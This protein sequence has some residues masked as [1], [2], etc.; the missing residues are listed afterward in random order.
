MTVDN[1][2][3]ENVYNE[4]EVIRDA[5]ALSGTLYFSQALYIVRGFIIAQVLGPSTYGVWSIFRSFFGSAPYFGMGTQQAMLREVPFS[6]GEGDKFKKKII[7]Q[8]TL[9]WNILLTSV[10]MVIVLILSFTGFAAGYRIEIQLAG[11]LFVLNAIH[12]F[13]RPKFKSEQKIFLLSKYLL[14]YAVLNTV[15]GLSFLF[16][17]KLTGLLMGMILAQLVLLTFLIINN[18]L[19]LN[20][21]IDKNILKEL[22][23]IGFPIMLLWF[24]VFLMGNADKFIVFIMLGKTKAGYYGLAAFVSSMVS[25]ISYSISTVIFPRMMYVFGKTHEIKQIEKY[26]KKP[27]IILSGITPVI[28]G[29]IYINIEAVINLFLPQYIPGITVL[30][31]LIAALF[32]STIWGLPTNLLIALNKQKKFM[33]MTA[34]I[35][36]LGIILDLVIIRAG[37]DMNGVAVITTFIFF[38]ASAVANSYALFSLKYKL[39]VIF[40]HLSVIYFPFIYSFAVM[41]FIVSISISKNIFFDNLLKSLIFLTSTIPLIF[42]I[43]KHSNIISKTLASFKIFKN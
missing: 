15:F 42:Y 8:T 28:L 35:L 17:F 36:L 40:K 32:F 4:G 14:S 38:L 1:T 7:I 24:L 20:L 21:S 41:V 6:I 23:R 16:F 25:Y 27:I 19:S 3:K 31:I 34:F 18:H 13:M 5:A 11:I 22:F 26:F 12:L 43:E 39:K 29:I 10:V 37:F 9:S 30:H 33:Y 2:N